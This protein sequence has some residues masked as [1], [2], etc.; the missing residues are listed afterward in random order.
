[1]KWQTIGILKLRTQEK[2]MKLIALRIIEDAGSFKFT[3][4]K[5]ESLKTDIYIELGKLNG[6]PQLHFIM[7]HLCRDLVI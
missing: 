2:D 3:I 6:N 5:L 4:G 1:M 7:E